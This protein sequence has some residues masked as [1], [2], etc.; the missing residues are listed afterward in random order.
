MRRRLTTWLAMVVMTVMLLAA[1]AFAQGGGHEG[2]ICEAPDHPGH[3]EYAK[4]HIVPL[5]HAD[6]ERLGQD[7]KPGKE[8]RGYAG[9]CG[10]E[11][12]GE[13]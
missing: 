1:P 7:H 10:E 4:H 9:L 12:P 2:E 8:H 11:E 6:D 5:A 13:E 3:S